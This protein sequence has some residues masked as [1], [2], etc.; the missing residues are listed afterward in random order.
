MRH[1][2]GVAEDWRPRPQRAACGFND[3]RRE[4]DVLGDF[5]HAT[6]MDD[7]HGDA[8]L[9]RREAGKIRLGAYGREGA[10]IDRGAV[11]DIV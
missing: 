10:L 5:N 11:A 2:V 8:L 4:D 3:A 6:G 1:H 7:A 9:Q